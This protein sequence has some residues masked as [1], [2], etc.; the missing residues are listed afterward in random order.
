MPAEMLYTYLI[1]D[2]YGKPNLISDTSFLAFNGY[3]WELQGK[4]FSKKVS[5][6]QG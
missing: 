4:R 2:H 1:I 3:R 5:T 6:E